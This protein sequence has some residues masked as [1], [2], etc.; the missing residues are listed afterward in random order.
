MLLERIIVDA[1]SLDDFTIGCHV[2]V[3]QKWRVYSVRLKFVLDYL[4][5]RIRVK[6][7][8]GVYN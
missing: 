4:L 5:F 7:I 2:L 6:W 8:R 3:P 1:I